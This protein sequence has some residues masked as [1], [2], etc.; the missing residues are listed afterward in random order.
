[1]SHFRLHTRTNG[2]DRLKYVI[3][4]IAC[5]LAVGAAGY[6]VH[7]IGT[8]RAK[9]RETVELHTGEE[10]EQ[11]LLD[12]ESES[13]NLNGSYRLEE[14]LE[15]GWLYQSIGNNVEPFTGTF[16]GNG[17][18]ISGLER[19]LFGVVK[20]A[21]IENLFFSGA[22]ITEPFTYYD[23]EHYVDGYSALAA[24]AVDSKI[25]NCGMNG[26]IYTASPSEAEYQAAKASPADAEERKKPS[27]T[28]TSEAPESSTDAAGNGAAGGAGGSVT[29]VTEENSGNGAGIGNETDNIQEETSDIEVSVPDNTN[30]ETGSQTESN[31]ENPGNE[32]GQESGDQTD[33]SGGESPEQSGTPVPDITPAENA[34]QSTGGNQESNQEQPDAGKTGVNEA[35]ESR[36]PEA[37]AENSNA[38]VHP[39]KR[40]YLMLKI[41]ELPDAEAEAA[42][43]ASPSDADQADGEKTDNSQPD[44]EQVEPA[45]PSDA[46]APEADKEEIEYIGNPFGDIYILVTA[47]RVTAG[48]L[49]AETAGETLISDSF[50][51]V[52]L[53]SEL[54]GVETYAGGLAGILG[55]HTRTENSYASG[56][57]S[58]DD[59]AGGFAAVND[60][61]VENSYSSMVLGEAGTIRGG[62]T[63]LGTGKFKGCVYDKQMACAEDRNEDTELDETELEE[64]LPGNEPSGFPDQMPPDEFQTETEEDHT[65]MIQVGPGEWIEAPVE[66]SA[67][68]E[69]F[70]NPEQPEA[71]PAIASEPASPSQVRELPEFTLKGLPTSQMVGDSA[72]IPGVW[73]YSGNAYPQLEDFAFS[74]QETIADSSKASAI[75]LILPDEYTLSDILQ[76]GDLILPSEID[77]QEIQWEAEGNVTIDENNRVHSETVSFSGHEVPEV[78]SPIETTAP[79]ENVLAGDIPAGDVISETTEPSQETGK[80]E[81]PATPEETAGEPNEETAGDILLKGTVGASSKEF[82]VP[83]LKSVTAYA[84]T[85][86]WQNIAEKVESGELPNMK[87]GQN[88]DDGYYEIDTPEALAWFAYKVNSGDKKINARLIENIDLFGGTHTGNTYVEARDNIDD[89]LPWVPIGYSYDDKGFQGVFDGNGK[90][91]SHMLINDTVL[92]NGVVMDH[93]GFIGV[94]YSEDGQ[95]ATVKDLGVQSGKICNML[96]GA[97]RSISLGGIVG[98]AGGLGK[99][100]IWRCWNGAQTTYDSTVLTGSTTYAGG[101]CARTLQIAPGEGGTVAI[102]GCYNTGSIKGKYTG[103]II[104]MTGSSKSCTVINCYNT[105]Q[106]DGEASAGGIVGH[107]NPGNWS[108]QEIIGCYNLGACVGSNLADKGGIYGY[109]SF[110]TKISGCFYDSSVSGE[111]SKLEGLSQQIGMTAVT[112]A[113]LN[114]WAAAFA[115]NNYGLV[116]ESSQSSWTW[117]EGGI[118]TLYNPSVTPE[119]KLPPAKDWSVIGQGVADGLMGLRSTGLK[120]PI[121]EGDGSEG[122]PYIIT[123]AEQL[124]W[125]A[126]L[127]NLSSESPN[128]SAKM[129][130]NMDLSGIPYTGYTSAEVEADITKALVWVPICE[131]IGGS[132]NRL[133]IGTFDGSGHYVTNMYAIGESYQGFFS[134]IGSTAASSAVVK[135]FGVKSGKVTRPEGIVGGSDA[136]ITAW[137][138]GKNVVVQRCWNGAL[139]DSARYGGGII[140]VWSVLDSLIEDCYNVGEVRGKDSSGGIIG[141]LSRNNDNY[142][143]NCYNLG[144]VTVTISGTQM[145]V[146][147]GGIIGICRDGGGAGSMYGLQMENCYSAGKVVGSITST[148]GLVGYAT[149]P[150]ASV[151]NCYYDKE[152]SGQRAAGGGITAEEAPGLTTE[153]AKSWALAYGLNGYRREAKDASA[154]SFTW[155]EGGYPTLYWDGKT[156]A[157]GN[158]VEKLGPAKD[159]G[160]IGLGM[161]AGLIGNGYTGEKYSLPA[162]DGVTTP[163]QIGSAEQLAWFANKITNGTGSTKLNVELTAYIDLGGDEYVDSGNLLWVPIGYNPAPNIPIENLRTYGGTF[164]GGG[165]MID[166]MEVRIKGY[167][168]LFSMAGE[169]AVIKNLGVGPRSTVVS[170]GNDDT[171]GSAAAAF[172]GFGYSSKTWV[173]A[174]SGVMPLLIEGCYTRATVKGFKVDCTG[175]IFGTDNRLY[176]H[177][178]S[179]R[180]ARIDGCYAAGSVTCDDGTTQGPAYAIAGTFT[181]QLSLGGGINNCYW[182][183]NILSSSSLTSASS[184]NVGVNSG[185][186]TQELKDASMISLLN[187]SITDKNWIYNNP[188]TSKVNDGYPILKTR[189]LITTWGDV[190]AL[191]LPAPTVQSPSSDSSTYGTEDNP[192]LLSSAEDLAW[193]ANEVNNGKLNL[194]G[195]MMTDIDLFGSKYSG[196]SCAADGSNM[197]SAIVWVSMGLSD[198]S[199]WEK[200]YTGTFDGNGYHVSNVV[201]EKDKTF[202]GFISM[203]GN[204][205]ASGIVIN[206][207]VESGKITGRIAGGIAAISVG[208][209]Q[210]RRCW[211][212][213]E[214]TSVTDYAGGIAGELTSFNGIAAKYSPVIEGCY[215]LG[216][217]STLAGSRGAGIVSYVSGKNG[218]AGTGGRVRNCYNLGEITGE[219][220][221]AGIVG[222]FE[223]GGMAS[224]LVE[225]CYNGGQCTAIGEGYSGYGIGF[226]GETSNFVNCY[227]DTTK[228]EKGILTTGIPSS[229]IRGIGRDVMKSW[230]TAWAL[231]GYGLES[232]GATGV[233]DVTDTTDSSFTWKVGEYPTLHWS[234]DDDFETNK[235]RADTWLDVGY[236]VENQL[237]GERDTN[238]LI[239]VPSGSGTTSAP[240]QLANAEQLAWFGYMTGNDTTYLNKSAQVQANLDLFGEKYTGEVYDSTRNNMEQALR[241]IPI[242]KTA[243]GGSNGNFGGVFDGAGCHVS[244][245]YVNESTVGA[246]FL[247]TLTGGTIKDFGVESGKVV[248]SENAVGGVAGSVFLHGTVLRCWNKAPVK[249]LHWVGG[250]IGSLSSA[251][252]T[253]TVEGCYNS[254]NV[255]GNMWSGG[256]AGGSGDVKVGPTIRNCGNVGNVSG[257]NAGGIVNLLGLLEGGTWNTVSN[258]YNAGVITGTNTTGA[259]MSQKEGTVTN[260][261]YD[262]TKT[263]NPGTG[264]STTEAKALATEQLQSWAAAYA[265]NGYG[266]DQTEDSFAG[267]ATTESAWT[268]LPTGSTPVY[269]TICWPGSSDAGAPKKLGAP[270]SW[271]DVGLGVDGGLIGDRATGAVT[272]KPTGAGSTTTPYLLANAEQLAWFGYQV[273]HGSYT[274]SGKMTTDIDLFGTPYTGITYDAGTDNINDAV[275][276][277]PMGLRNSGWSAGYQGTFDGDGYSLN[278]LKVEVTGFSNMAGFI[279]VLGG[280]GTSGIVK[281]L[282]LQSGKITSSAYGGGIAGLM[283]GQ[284]SKISGCWNGTDIVGPTGMT[285]SALGGIVGLIGIADYRSSGLMIEGC[286]NEGTI[287]GKVWKDSSFGGVA[288]RLFNTENSVI[289]NC[290]NQGTIAE[291]AGEVKGVGGILGYVDTNANGNRVEYCYNSGNIASARV[292][293]TGA[294]IGFGKNDGTAVTG[295]YYD[296]ANSIGIKSPGANITE[297]E[298]RSLTTDQLQSWAAAYALNRNGMQNSASDYGNFTWKSG[299]YPTL[300]YA[301]SSDFNTKKLQPAESWEVI[302]QGVKDQLLKD[303]TDAFIPEPVKDGTGAYSIECAEQ[304]GWFG[305]TVNSDTANQTLNANLTKDIDLLGDRYGG[306][307]DARIPWI[308]IETYQG[309]LGAGQPKVYQI[310]NLFAGGVPGKVITNAGLIGILSNNGKVTQIGMET[311][312]IGPADP[313]ARRGI[314]GGAIAGIMDGAGTIISR[315]YTRN[316]T[317]RV[318]AVGGAAGGI[319]GAVKAGGKIQD[320]YTIDSTLSCIGTVSGSSA[321]ACGIAG[322]H[323]AGGVPIENCYVAGNTLEAKASTSAGVTAAVGYNVIKKNCYS[324]VTGGSDVGQ[325]SKSQYQTNQL[326]TLDATERIGDDRVWYTSLSGEA[327]HGYPTLDAPVKLTAELNPSTRLESSGGD[328]KGGSL[329]SQVMLRGIREEKGDD[330]TYKAVNVNN[331]AANY[332]TYGYESANKMLAFCGG[333]QTISDVSG[334]SLTDPAETSK[335]PG[336]T[337]VSIYNAAAYNAPKR[338][339]MLDMCDTQKTTRYEIWITLNDPASKTLSLTVPVNPVTIELEP[340]KKRKSLS[341]EVTVTNENDYPLTGRISGV[342]TLTDKDVELMPI[343][344]KLDT[345][346]E[347]T[348]LLKAG[349]KLGISGVGGGTE[350]YYYN[351]KD[352]ESWVTYNLAG[353]KKT[354]ENSLNFHYFMDYSPLYAGPEQTFGY[355]I[356]YSV[357]LSK[358]DVAAAEM[359]AEAAGSGS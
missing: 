150:I 205:N 253:M 224:E 256:I 199:T 316:A 81:A 131:Y 112:P 296:T 69:L 225:N 183:T 109:L 206:L 266:G 321:S 18:V 249:G 1:M 357:S 270:D 11:Y 207:G 187:A 332:S 245:L 35:E 28:E 49:V 217:V 121:P 323:Y 13:Y 132:G 95:T 43:K 87:P 22:L 340:G 142:I 239:P 108:G 251:R 343:K 260:C 86:T 287:A 6:A 9:S 3:A 313:N 348:D 208:E 141:Q 68:E 139:I 111:G 63:A 246:G 17:H 285:G 70:E 152:S 276:W 190:V 164:D 168:G 242:G 124:A 157:D 90:T 107:S 359:T 98:V 175:S 92:D 347:R 204:K 334:A 222:Y 82:S 38:S 229:S 349:V 277:K 196:V 138:E 174:N 309:V 319:A 10:L 237:L 33:I 161:E 333:N 102:D 258:C 31:P 116:S 305:M 252:S 15:L 180:S 126:N 16:D 153:Q 146:G 25:R 193:F 189:N 281:N 178:G 271:E 303:S 148:G 133:Y 226:N 322:Y 145:T 135:D 105:G 60:G 169:G 200:G 202:Q 341:E 170:L 227:Y 46:K 358:D 118:P 292:G 117:T 351:P 48:G 299:E 154:S 78:G 113:Q 24:Y 234:G 295:C 14:D 67:A 29:D 188:A 191:G 288:G 76:D 306:T 55:A 179:T 311:P 211:N 37:T 167:A 83:G 129:T 228:S 59:T 286:W 203:L 151:K 330:T 155:K 336:F 85:G 65:V 147:S 307:E 136:G 182:D 254:G 291:D 318:G 268:Y 42:A 52:S 114:N 279:E 96:M 159:W 240:Y 293:V 40:Q 274:I 172:V 47:D 7:S 77:G 144:P 280:G 244:N 267:T 72:Q 354:G 335:F 163:Y 128:I 181:G 356:R 232:V 233:T 99:K 75:A 91:I 231:N 261:Y 325:L 54:D 238:Q 337:R 329:P 119:K 290:Y 218:S 194:C 259:I 314:W 273:N 275:K 71:D 115:L 50:V 263:A 272:A 162:G 315:C 165:Y 257:T 350:E 241:W 34:E 328:I 342:T 197:D 308:P 282:G 156:D 64:T 51:L 186:T 171:Y 103:G 66:Q 289:Q 185:K 221:A 297:S 39:V 8:A 236:A 62:F 122:S 317:V 101:I 176:Y 248:C 339:F 352:G 302:G 143:R 184:G 97:G 310:K 344:A 32:G 247:G 137:A 30:Q 355:T 301:G 255:T 209:S 219:T 192:Y 262:T 353:S 57:L 61:Q 134:M 44:K 320:C 284:G 278:H 264:F 84:V 294:I 216:K 213:A 327:T 73:Y 120:V 74:S 220:A 331:I 56:V 201:T 223:P 23:D 88:A 324:D 12:S 250:I 300:C 110:A 173:T 104:G 93:K 100:E 41:S 80:A 19:P 21:E 4:G 235:L 230:G 127:V 149:K 338:T 269:P 140:G 160:A 20:K 58:C 94:L 265:L 26:E 177:S 2:K 215:N 283:V 130:A 243:Q 346:D 298:A 214:V 345:I 106:I 79:E 312:V 45:S 212:G 210:I 125:F 53:S 158:A 198:T 36:Q 166:R 27:E 304:L 123:N 195:K 89:A 5:I 326:N